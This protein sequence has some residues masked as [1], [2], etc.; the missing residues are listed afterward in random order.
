MNL[1]LPPFEYKVQKRNNIVFIYDIIRKKYI[2]LTP[3]EWVRQH[4]IHYLIDVKHYPAALIA[5]E[6][7]IELNGLK[8]RYDIVCY[9]KLANP[10][11]I[12]ECKA[13]S[14]TLSQTTFDQAFEY[15][16]ILNAK[17][18][19]ITNGIRHLCGTIGEDG[20]FRLLDEIPEYVR[21]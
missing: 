5:V 6:R 9:N 2:V 4:V 7:E 14:I 11:L 13:P 12:V 1:S 8:R 18:V 15:N 19:L 10:V 3:E 17:Y 20:K 16:T 21:I